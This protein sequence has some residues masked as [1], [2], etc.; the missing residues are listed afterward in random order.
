[1]IWNTVGCAYE[2]LYMLEPTDRRKCTYLL[3]LWHNSVCRDFQ[4]AAMANQGRAE[5]G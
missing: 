4:A 1:M 5:G 3:S 2:K